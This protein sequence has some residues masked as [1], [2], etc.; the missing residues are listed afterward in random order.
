[1]LFEG[2]GLLAVEGFEILPTCIAFEAVEGLCYR[3]YGLFVQSP[4]LDQERKILVLD[5]FV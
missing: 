3:V 1:M 4:G 2:Y 5:P